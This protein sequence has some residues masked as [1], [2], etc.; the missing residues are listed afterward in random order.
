[1]TIFLKGLYNLKANGWL[2]YDHENPPWMM[3]DFSRQPGYQ[4]RKLLFSEFIQ[5]QL[6]L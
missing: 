3:G 6:Q 5:V 1:M 4:P 2:G